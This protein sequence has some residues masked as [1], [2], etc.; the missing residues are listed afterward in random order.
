MTMKQK[1]PQF[2]L[3][4]N[5]IIQKCLKR[6]TV[7]IFVSYVDRLVQFLWSQIY[8]CTQTIPVDCSSLHWHHRGSRCTHP[9]LVNITLSSFNPVHVLLQPVIGAIFFYSWGS[10]FVD[11]QNVTGLFESNF[12]GKVTVSGITIRNHSFHCYILLFLGR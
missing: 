4:I 8:R 12:L 10:M 9:H 11:S 3:T 1:K 5:K 6:V 7:S 2:R